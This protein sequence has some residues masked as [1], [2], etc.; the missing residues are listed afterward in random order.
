VELLQPVTRTCAASRTFELGRVDLGAGFGLAVHAFTDSVAW[1]ISARRV[2]PAR[3]ASRRE[4]SGPGRSLRKKEK[5][6]T[7]RD[8]AVFMTN[9]LPPLNGWKEDE[10]AP[11][12]EGSGLETT[13]RVVLRRWP[14]LAGFV[15]AIRS[16]IS[17]RTTGSSART[18]AARSTVST[19]PVG[20]I[21]LLEEGP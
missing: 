8:E 21:S 2:P 10:S 3:R 6:K 16:D 9:T 4:R 20:R 18:R 17:R 13:V 12:T 19:R 5:R 7:D 11:D 14:S 15:F 1:R